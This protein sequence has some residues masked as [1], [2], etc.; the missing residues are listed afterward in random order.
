[1]QSN[2]GALVSSTKPRLRVVNWLAK[3]RLITCLSWLSAIRPGSDACILASGS[4]RT[5]TA[6]KPI[7]KC[8]GRRTSDMLFTADRGV[9]SD[10]I[11]EYRPSVSCS[12]LIKPDWEPASITLSF[13][14]L[15][16]EQQ[17]DFV[18]V[19][20]RCLPF[21]PACHLARTPNEW[22]STVRCT[23]L[24]ARFCS[25]CRVL[26]HFHLSMFVHQGLVRKKKK[27]IEIRICSKVTQ[28]CLWQRANR[29]QV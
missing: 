15:D 18:T 22:H 9:I 11:G 16:I 17:F 23:A 8:A 13:D 27:R 14:M 3:W 10:G 25:S 20:R 7:E 19:R 6:A 1:M 28:E 24:T 4:D 21:L 2:Y 29:F 26:S 12:W 5:L